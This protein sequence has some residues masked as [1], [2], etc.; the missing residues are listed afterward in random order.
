MTANQ[1]QFRWMLAACI[2]LVVAVALVVSL[3]VIPAVHAATVPD[4]SPEDAVPAFQI[5][6]GLH[7]LAAL[8]L[9]L[10]AALSKARSRISTSSLV[11]TGVAV[12]FLGFVLSDAA[13]AFREAGPSM[14]AV[15]ILLFVCVGADVLAGGMS[16]RAAFLR[17]KVTSDGL[18][19]AST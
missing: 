8:I 10:V 3:G 15:A 19:G 16:I 17:P 4:I 1:V 9:A 2:I 5:A 7:I 18:T 13:L 12:L 6:V 14:Q 11:V